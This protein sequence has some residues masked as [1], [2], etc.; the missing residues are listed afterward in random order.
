MRIY[1]SI[2]TYLL[3][4]LTLSL[5]LKFFG[6]LFISGSE[7]LSYGLIFF[8]I[9]SVY[10]SFGNRQKYS[11]FLG[12]VIFLAGLLIFFVE[13]FFIFWNVPILLSASAFIIGIS[14][15]MLFLDELKNKTYLFIGTFFISVGF[16]FTIILGHISLLLFIESIFDVIIN[17]WLVVLIVLGILILIR[18]EERE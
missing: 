8:G 6:V 2:V 18:W 9:S 13:R 14:F 16:L 10:I 17:Y 12:S 7:I 11:L 3:L 4:F 5:V 15:L 1:Q